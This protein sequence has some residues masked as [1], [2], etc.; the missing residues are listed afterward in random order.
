MVAGLSLIYLIQKSAQDRNA[1]HRPA[2]LPD[3]VSARANDWQWEQTRDGRPVVRVWAGDQKLNA[4]GNRLELER[5]RLHLY[6]KDGKA[7]DRVQSAH[8]EFDLPS[9]LL[10][11]DGEVE[12]TMAVP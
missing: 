4:E 1:P 2:T 10:Y 9:G 7:Y 12:I 5:V 6:H 11:S 3:T 8:A